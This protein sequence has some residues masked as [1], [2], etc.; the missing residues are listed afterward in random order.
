M[1]KWIVD[2]L[3]DID[4][5]VSI[6]GEAL[7]GFFFVGSIF[8][9]L[10]TTFLQL[11]LKCFQYRH[12]NVRVD[13]QTKQS[14]KYYVSTRAQ[15]TDPCD[16]D[17]T[18]DLSIELIPYFLKQVFKNSDVQ[19]YMILADSG[20]GK[21]TFLL[22]LF[23]A[24]Y[25]KIFRRHKIVFIPLSL[26]ETDKRINKIKNKHNTILLLDG[27]D[28]DQD[29]MEDYVSRL[30]T[31]CK[32]TEL[33]YKVIISCRTQFFP[34]VDSEPQKISRLKFGVGNKNVEFVKYYISPFNDDEI[35]LY[36]KK[37][38]KRHSEKDK[39]IISKKII[40]N[41]PKLMVRPMLLSYID[42][43]VSDAT[44]RYD[45]TYEV[46]KELIYKWV[47][48]EASDNRLLYEFS[49][50]VAEHMLRNKTLYIAG[51]EIDELCREYNIIIRKVEAKSR[52]LLNRNAKGYYKFAHKS[53][54]E[55]FLA[56]K[57]YDDLDFRKIFVLE[58]L[59]GYD[60][61]K[62]F[63]EEMS[64]AYLQDRLNNDFKVLKAGSFQFLQLPN[65]DFSNKHLINCNFE[66]CNLYKSNFMLADID[67]VK[68]DK[69]ILVEAD[70]RGATLRNTS[71]NDSFLC[72]AN[73]QGADLFNAELSGANL[74]QA[75]FVGAN[76]ECAN[77]E[78]GNLNKASF[79]YANLKGIK[80]T[81]ASLKATVFIETIF[82]YSNLN[83]VDFSEAYLYYNGDL[84]MF[85]LFG[86]YYHE[87]LEIWDMLWGEVKI[88]GAIFSD[89]QISMLKDHVNFEGTKVYIPTSEE[90]IEYDV[91]K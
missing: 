51:N 70:F 28:E 3:S 50:K 46:Y 80:I 87:N 83:N 76:L 29:A 63:L 85:L 48:R 38:Y 56:K 24:Y 66:G 84:E 26:E 49:E 22:N 78:N 7:R 34:N 52:S 21:T 15:S 5:I 30:N 6:I 75:N 2:N 25:K 37:K 88:K 45:Y 23:F 39:I 90:L 60:M 77:I 8:I 86:L 81:N 82:A 32:E 11:K 74:E 41:C 18:P 9:G 43:L 73:M 27:L 17:T 16:D 69:A 47:K 36:L 68:F 62:L 58:G 71:L 4:S 72:R 64:F 44:K 91:Y 10:I 33:F 89:Y 61:S 79:S 12:L 1:F 31:I 40:S 53:I 65:I 55:Y 14:M 59:K 35:N 13:R 67:D 19:Y 57:A 42:D 54:M 20:M